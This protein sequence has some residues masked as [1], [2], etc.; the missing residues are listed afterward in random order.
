MTNEV[1]NWL[2]QE[3]HGWDDNPHANSKMHGDAG[4]V[5]E[6]MAERAVKPLLA[7][8]EKLNRKCSALALLLYGPNPNAVE[9]LPVASFPT[10]PCGVAYLRVEGGYV[11]VCDC[12]VK[13][14]TAV[15]SEG[16][17]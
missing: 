5:A 2:R 6:E 11:P 16:G 8:I 9:P 17:T 10:C 12:A 3:F 4:I 1:L 13:N 14:A 7:E 15:K